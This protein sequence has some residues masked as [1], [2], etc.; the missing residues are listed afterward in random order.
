MW[1][2]RHPAHRGTCL[3]DGSGG[4]LLLVFLTTVLTEVEFERFGGIVAV[5]AQRLSPAALTT[6]ILLFLGVPD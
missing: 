6:L 5:R 2:T 4:G 3:E 1:G